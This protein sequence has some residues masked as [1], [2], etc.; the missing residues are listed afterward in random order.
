MINLSV[1]GISEA[2][3][4]LREIIIPWRRKNAQQKAKFDNLMR[5]AEIQRLNAETI[6][7]RA[8]AERERISSEIDIKQADLLSSQSRKTE[9]EAELILAQAEKVRVEAEKERAILR[10]SQIALAL[11]IIEH[12]A[13][14]ANF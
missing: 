7:S 10:Q 2:A 12:Y 5:Q 11:K 4:T 14:R 9:A 8:K 6:L 13:P 1:E 3:E